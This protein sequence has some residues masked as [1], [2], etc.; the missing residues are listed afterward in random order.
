LFAFTAPRAPQG[1]TGQI[2]VTDC[3]VFECNT[4]FDAAAKFRSRFTVKYL[5]MLTLQ[6]VKFRMLSECNCHKF[7][8]V[9]HGSLSAVCVAVCVAVY[10]CVHTIMV[11]QNDL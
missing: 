1:M 2:A 8:V 5:I 11:E 10:W 6:V 3:L 9:R 4:F 7:L